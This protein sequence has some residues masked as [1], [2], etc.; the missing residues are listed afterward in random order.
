MDLN[1]G[2]GWDAFKKAIKT[3]DPETPC[4]LMIKYLVNT[5]EKIQIDLLLFFRKSL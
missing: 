5:K 1:Y 2:K 4:S 3:S